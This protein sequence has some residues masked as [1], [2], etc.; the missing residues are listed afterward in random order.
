MLGG[1]LA[2]LCILM[3]LVVLIVSGYLLL[4]FTQDKTILILLLRTTSLQ[5]KLKTIKTENDQLYASFAQLSNKL[6][7]IEEGRTVEKAN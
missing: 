7:E 5:E 3:G 2:A 6:D 1:V 4:Q